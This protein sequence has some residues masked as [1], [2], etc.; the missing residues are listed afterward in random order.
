MSAQRQPQTAKHWCPMATLKGVFPKER[1]HH[2]GFERVVAKPVL[3]WLLWMEMA[4]AS[5][6]GSCCRLRWIPPQDLNT[7]RSAFS[8][9]VTPQRK[10][11]RGSPE[12]TGNE[13][14]HGLTSI[15]QHCEDLIMTDH[16]FFLPLS[17][18]VITT[19][20]ITSINSGF[21]EKIQDNN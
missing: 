3:T 7:Q 9:S 19:K 5:L 10:R 12:E 8:T 4:Q 6:S 20:Y 21:S 13:S 16:E 15:Y 11:T 14:G 18:H 2:I 17:I 1:R